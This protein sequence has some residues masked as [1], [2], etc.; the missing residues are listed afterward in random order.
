MFPNPQD[1]LP[2]PLRPNRERYKKLAKDLVN[3]CKSVDPDAIGDW[4]EAWVKMLVKRS[5]V[6][7]GRKESRVIV[8]RTEQVEAFVQRTLSN[9]DGPQCRLADAQFV[10]AR[11]HGFESWPK[12]SKHLAQLSR[13]SSVVARF[14]AAADAICNGNVKTLRRLLSEEPKLIR[15]RSTR[16]H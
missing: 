16:E 2:L 9:I 6:K 4:A 1:A 3:A 13:K 5:G 7:L 8:R 10:I 15:S 12:F 14:E 11:S